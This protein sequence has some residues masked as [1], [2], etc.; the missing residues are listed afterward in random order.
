MNILILSRKNY[1]STRRLRDT[2]RRLGHSV[3]VIDPFSKLQVTSHKPASSSGGSQVTKPKTVVI[4]RIGVIGIEY[5][6]NLIRHFESRGIPVINSSRAINLTKDK[7]ASLEVLKRRGLPV[8]K[9]FMIRSMRLLERVI[10]Q[11]GGLP[12]VIKPLRGSQG[13]GVILAK[14]MKTVKSILKSA[15]EVDYDIIIQQFIPE[16]RGQDIRILVVGG[17]VIAAMRRYPPKDDFRSN[18]HQGGR[19]ELIELS[20]LHKKMALRA[21]KTL[22]LQLAGVDMIE[23]RH[24]PLIVE[25]NTSPGFEGLEAVT[26]IDIARRIIDFATHFAR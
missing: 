9:T 11:S 14:R 22:G 20:P 2:A 1:Y 8:P 4:P 15:W 18:I 25:V 6:L 7:F 3:K 5:S 23:S 21:V 26:G 10:K 16:S 12:V 13:V 17:K 19:A 24:G